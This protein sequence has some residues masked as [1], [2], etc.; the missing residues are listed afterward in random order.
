MLCKITLL[1]IT[2]SLTE[3][4]STHVKYMAYLKE[5]AKSGLCCEIL[6]YS[7]GML[8]HKLSFNICSV[9][10]LYYS[11]LENFFFVLF[12]TSNVVLGKG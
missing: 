11:S 10:G 5:R 4:Y 12:K 1:Y 7:Q 9:L 3:E 6:C 2:L 8:F